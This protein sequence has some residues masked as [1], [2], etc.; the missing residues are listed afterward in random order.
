[1]ELFGQLETERYQNIDED[2][3]AE[4]FTEAIN[5]IGQLFV[6]PDDQSDIEKGRD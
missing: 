3:T 2:N 5:P 6:G 1:M 4:S